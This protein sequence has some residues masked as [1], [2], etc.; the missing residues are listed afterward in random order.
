[1]YFVFALFVLI[2]GI[3]GVSSKQKDREHIRV[4]NETRE[5]SQWRGSCGGTGLLPEFES[6]GISIS[7]PAKNEEP[8]KGNSDVIV[9]VLKEME[10]RRLASPALLRKI[11]QLA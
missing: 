3:D 10:P 11:W 6:A 4:R 1:M 8:M 2:R 7:T 9:A 5:T